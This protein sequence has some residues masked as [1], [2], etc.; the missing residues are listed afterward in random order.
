M[1][2]SEKLKILFFGELPPNVVHG[3][4]ISN[5]INTDILSEI[6]DLTIVEEKWSLQYHNRFAF[7]KIYFTLQSMFRVWKMINKNSFDLYYTVLYVSAFGGLKNIVSVILFKMMNRKTKLLFHIHRSDLI[8]VIHRSYIFKKYIQFFNKAGV[9]FIVLSEAQK[10]ECNNFLDRVDVLYNCIDENEVYPI[11]AIN[12]GNKATQLLFISNYIKEKG[13]L[14][15]LEAFGQIDLKRTI[16][17]VCHG[18]FTDESTKKEIV[19][20]TENS[21]NIEIREAIYGEDKN[22]VLN[23]ADIVVLPSHNEGLPL[24]LLEA[25]RLQK[26][27]VI[28]KVGY[29]S[30]ILG[31]DYSLYCR[32]G[33]VDSIREALI[34]AISVTKSEVGNFKSFMKNVYQKVS[35]EQ[36]RIMFK[37]IVHETLTFS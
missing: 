24:V 6:G 5:K 37:K 22:R 29:I 16:N 17:L 7:H 36:H 2:G 30:E 28:S 23:T 25:L 10:K 32:V 27:I 1:T 12:N 20:L 35:Y 4:S 11:K 9:T 15:L 26:L 21:Q 8:E 3:V 34:N 33:D 14:E 13:I 31:E 18:G 19:K